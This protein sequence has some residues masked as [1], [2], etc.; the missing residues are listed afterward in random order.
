M[1]GQRVNVDAVDVWDAALDAFEQT[2]DAQE[3]WLSAH[4]TDESAPT[5]APPPDLPPLPATLAGRAGELAAR[6][7]ALLERAQTM[8][9]ATRPAESPARAARLRVVPSSS[10]F[11]EMA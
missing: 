3:R 6:S 8:S 9:D 7:D 4:G 11:D 5:F 10:T 1:V 2:V